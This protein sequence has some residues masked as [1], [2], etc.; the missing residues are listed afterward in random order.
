MS[1]TRI[2]TGADALVAL[3]GLRKINNSLST[4]LER[5]SSGLRI[6]KAAD[7]PTGVGTLTTARA[8]LGGIRAAQ[9]NLEQTYSM[10]SQADGALATIGDALVKMKELAVKGANDA[11]LTT[12]QITSIGAEYESLGDLIDNIS[13]NTK[14][15]EKALL[16]GD[17]VGVTV[18]Y[19]PNSTDTLS[20]ID[21]IGGNAD[22]EFATLSPNPQTGFTDAAGAQTA[23]DDV[24][25]AITALSDLRATTGQYMSLI[26]SNLSAQLSAE[27]NVASV[28]S[29]VGDADLASEIS[30]MARDSIL[31]QSATAALMQANVQSQ[32][33]LKLLQ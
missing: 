19:G 6:N 20:A 24:D 14:F 16:D 25:A 30:N 4:S 15:G 9:M 13:A 33:V 27:I 18:Q 2:N 21:I 12:A 17:L 22:H 29:A 31:A 1:L 7:D 8:Q 5:I 11:T 23:M 32:I 10:L 3:N 26:Q 28:V